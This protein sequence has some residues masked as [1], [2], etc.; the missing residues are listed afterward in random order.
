MRRHIFAVT[1]TALALTSS[2]HGSRTVAAQA[3]AAPARPTD[4]RSV[5]VD[6][7]DR[8]ADPCVGFYQ[9]AC[10]GWGAKNPVRPDRRSFWRVSALRECN[11]LILRGRVD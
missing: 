8:K 7:V 1:C 11:L 4:A 10:G 2:P 5:E 9:F 3:S 6:A